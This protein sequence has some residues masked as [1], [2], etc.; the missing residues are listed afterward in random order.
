[1]KAVLREIARRRVSPEVAFRPKQGFTVPVERW[2]AERWSGM[3]GRLEGGT[4]LE[5][6]GWV[7]R[8]SLREP[9]RAAVASGAVPVQVWRLLVLEHWLEKTAAA[10]PAASS[11]R[12]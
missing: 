5:S 4:L 12:C 8:G 2:L 1:M 6:Q 10:E 9:I 3:L 11:V 7:R